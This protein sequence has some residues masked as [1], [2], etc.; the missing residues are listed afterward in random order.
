VARPSR[1]RSAI[2]ELVASSARHG[3]T[4]EEVRR[5]LADRGLDADPSS[6]FRGLVRLGEEGEID[7]VDLG[8]GKLRF[9]ARRGHHEHVRCEACGSV[10][11]VPGCLVEEVIPEIERQT[12]FV[13]TG[14]RVLLGGR[15]ER[16]AGGGV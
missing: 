9:E 4:I 15:C 14:H 2:G 6:V 12:G 10:R 7:R 13:I 8:D 11:E 3:W 1:V 5:A 16:C